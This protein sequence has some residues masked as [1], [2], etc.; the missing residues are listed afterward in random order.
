L[1]TGVT[2]YF[3][4]N[5]GYIFGAHSKQ[6]GTNV[7]VIVPPVLRVEKCCTDRTIIESITAALEISKKTPLYTGDLYEF[8]TELGSKTFKAFSQKFTSVKIFLRGDVCRVQ[9]LKLATKTGGYVADKEAVFECPV[10]E[11]HAHLSEMKRM[12]SVEDEMPSTAQFLT[13]SGS[14]VTYTPL[15]EGYKDLGDGHT[16]AYQ[17]FADTRNKNNVLSFIIDSGYA[18]FCKA[19]IQS[20]FTKYYGEL[21]E[22]RLEEFTDCLY[23]YKFSA[24]TRNRMIVSYLFKEQDALLEV[25]YQIELNASQEEFSRVQR[26]FEQLVSSIRI[27]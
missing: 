6:E 8:W 26:D 20:A 3:N 11:L 27:N 4:K 5:L 10:T 15:S 21:L 9:G 18:S 7:P 12:L 25:L 16:D 23:L 24:K 13:L 17:L 19:D 14:K 1:F 2:I 22:F